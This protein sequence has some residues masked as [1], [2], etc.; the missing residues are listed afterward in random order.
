VITGDDDFICGPVCSKEIAAG[1]QGAREVVV[2]DSGHMVFI[3]QARAF[4]D[5][6]A[7]FLE[8]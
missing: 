6:V 7:D 8:G 4:H 5:E 1:I 2:G 3:E